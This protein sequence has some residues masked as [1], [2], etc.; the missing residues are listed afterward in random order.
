[1]LEEQVGPAPDERRVECRPQR[2]VARG[3]GP[4][5]GDIFEGSICL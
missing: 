1:M 2:L 3:R 5:R 4:H